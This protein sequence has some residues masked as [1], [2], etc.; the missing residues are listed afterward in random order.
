MKS[1]IAPTNTPIHIYL[2]IYIYIDYIDIEYE[3][4]SILQSD[5]A[6]THTHPITRV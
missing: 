4:D 1:T 2:Y 3:I 6:F 5:S